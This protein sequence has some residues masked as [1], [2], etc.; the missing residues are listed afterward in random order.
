MAWD[1]QTVYVHAR[2]FY[3][4]AM[5]AYNVASVPTALAKA[6]AR[7]SLAWQEPVFHRLGFRV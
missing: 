6:V 7:F 3:G 4:K 5:F 2:G 1:F